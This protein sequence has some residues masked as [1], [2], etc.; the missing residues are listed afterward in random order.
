MTSNAHIQWKRKAFIIHLTIQ[1]LNSQRKGILITLWC[2]CAAL[3]PLPNRRY[4][5]C[6]DLYL[7]R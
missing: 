2:R 5:P 6:D 4:L 7:A 1:V 3:V